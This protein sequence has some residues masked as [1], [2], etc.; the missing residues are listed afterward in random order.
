[1]GTFFLLS[2]IILVF[3][4]DTEISGWFGMGMHEHTHP[5]A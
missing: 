2:Q 1:M 4:I 3:W 5:Y